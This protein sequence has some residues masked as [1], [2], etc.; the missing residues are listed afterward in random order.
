SKGVYEI[1]GMTENNPLEVF[2]GYDVN[3]ELM[4]PHSMLRI[5]GLLTYT[6][7]CTA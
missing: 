3:D 7:D 1:T 5:E 4:E 2:D 6:Q